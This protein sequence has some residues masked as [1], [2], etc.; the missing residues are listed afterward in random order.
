M[1][2]KKVSTIA[3]QAIC[4]ANLPRGGRIIVT[5]TF[6]RHRYLEP[7]LAQDLL[8]VVRT[9]LRPTI[10]VMNAAFGWLP[11]RDGHLQRPDREVTLHAVT[12]SPAD[13]ASGIQIQDHGKIQ[14]ALARPDIADVTDPFLVWLIRR[15]V[16][17]Q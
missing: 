2:L 9:I 4:K 8:V 7:V 11:E 12:H 10:R 15:E 14:P 16:P 6:A 5:I 1:V 3:R 17:I 13:D